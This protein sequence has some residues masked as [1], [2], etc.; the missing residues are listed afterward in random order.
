MTQPS[1]I[2]ISIRVS[3]QDMGVPDDVVPADFAARVAAL[4]EEEVTAAVAHAYPDAELD[5]DVRTTRE[6]Q[7][8]A[9]IRFTDA[10]GEESATDVR[11]TELVH[12]AQGRAWQRACEGA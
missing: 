7:A 4:T 6:A 10:D 11:V 5:V 9:T 12:E 1:T 8:K 2:E 3:T